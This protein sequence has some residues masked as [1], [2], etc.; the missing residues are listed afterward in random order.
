[1]HVVNATPFTFATVPGRLNYPGH[2]LTFVIKAT[3]KLS[4][5]GEASIHEVQQLPCGDVLYPDADPEQGSVWYES[6]FAPIKPGADVMVV[7]NAYTPGGRSAPSVNVAVRVGTVGRALSVVGDRPPGLGGDPTPFTSMPVR[8]ERA[9]G[10]AGHRLNPAGTG[11]RAVEDQETGQRVVQP[12]NIFDAREV[13]WFV[14]ELHEVTDPAATAPA[15][16][17]PAGLGPM[18]REWPTRAELLGTYDAAWLK[19]RFPAQPSDFDP[20]WFHAAPAELRAGEYL[21]GDEEIRLTNLHSRE[22]EYRCVLPGL[23]PRVFRNDLEPIAPGAEARIGSPL[24]LAMMGSFAEVP[25]VLDTVWIDAEAEV[26]VCVWRGW[27]EVSDEDAEEIAHVYIE[28]GADARGDLAS[29]RSRFLGLIEAAERRFDPE[30]EESEESVPGDSGRERWVEREA[31]EAELDRVQASP[32]ARAKAFEIMASTSDERLEAFRAEAR[33]AMRLAGLDPDEPPALTPEQKA[34]K[35]ELLQSWGMDPAQ[36]EAS[37]AI[38]AAK[39]RGAPRPATAKQRRAEFERGMLAS[40]MDA[41]ARALALEFFDLT[42]DRQRERMERDLRLLRRELG[43][44]PDNPPMLSPD[45]ERTRAGLLSGFGIEPD[46]VTMAE[47]AEIEAREERRARV[48]AE[49]PRDRAWVIAKVAQGES[50]AGEMLAEIDLS[51]ADL[52]GADFEGANLARANLREAILIGAVLTRANMAGAMAVGADLTGVAGASADLSGAV[53]SKA[54]VGNADLT[55][56]IL[57]EANLTG[58]MLDRSLLCGASLRRARAGGCSAIGADFGGADLSGADF[59]LA[60]LA[61]ADFTR[62]LG[63]RAVLRRANMRDARLGDADFCDADCAGITA[64]NLRASG[65]TKLRG[66]NFTQ[67]RGEGAKWQR[68]DL[69]NADFRFARLPGA[70]WTRAILDGADLSAA[71]LSGSTFRKAK[72]RGAKMI[73]ARLFRASLERADLSGADVSRANM[74]GAELLDIIAVGIVAEGVNLK[75]TKL[76]GASS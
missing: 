11:W 57:I 58:T 15:E 26:A 1:M 47:R 66:V 24:D 23:R 13:G 5:G 75:M 27:S 33:A 35:I 56:A 7:G 32:A 63:T 62:A 59:E 34:K 74:Y 3:L 6:D 25:L 45:A 22:A 38:A 12:P 10:G 54:R 16:P 21:S 49:Q 61:E 64:T 40:G 29:A 43:I 50:L 53:L 70:D 31:V 72:L 14:P 68:C 73:A 19:H 51:G 71:D 28:A 65:A 8:Y 42:P 69:T 41:R 46:L 17:S 37:E 67:A 20:A 36:V 55:G 4:P 2:T 60:D 30:P 9:F 76:A 52:S 18:R 48:A 44:D 39:G